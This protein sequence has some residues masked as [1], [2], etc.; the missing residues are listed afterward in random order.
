MIH[1]ISDMSDEIATYIGKK[2]FTIYKKNLMIDEE[3]YIRNTLTVRPFIP[4]SPIKLDSFPVYRES[5]KK[6]YIPR[7]FGIETYGAPDKINIPEGDDI[8]LKFKGDLRD[9]Q[10][11]IIQTYKNKIDESGGYG[12]GL[13]EIPCGRGK[14]LGKDTP[15]LMYN[16]SIKLVQDVRVG[17]ILMG[18]DS[19][20]RNVLSLARGRET[21]YE[22]KQSRGDAY[23]VNESHIL[24]LKDSDGNVVDISLSDYLKDKREDL[25]GYK[26]GIEYPK[27]E[28]D[29]TKYMN[30]YDFGFLISKN[31]L[32]EYKCIPDIY[33]LNCKEVQLDLITGLID[34]N[35]SNDCRHYYIM[36]KND[37]FID[38]LMF[39]CRCLKMECYM[40]KKETYFEIIL[41]TNNTKLNLRN[42]EKTIYSDVDDGLIDITISTISITKKDV[43][44]YYGFEI[45]GNRRFMLGDFTVTHNTVMALK[46]IELLKKKTL[47]IVHKGFLLNQWEERIEQFLPGARIGKIQGQIIDIENKDIV[48]AM[49]QSLSMKEYPENMFDSFGLTIVDEVHHISSEV[50][51][52]SLLKIITKYTLGLSATM[53]RKDGLSKVFKMFLGE[54]LYKEKRDTTDMVLIKALEYKVNDEKFNEIKY[55]FRGNPAYSSMISKLCEYAQRS[56]FILEVIKQELAEK[57]GQQIMILAHN[58]NILIYLF[59]AIEE[60]NIASVGYYLGGMKTDDLKASENKKII[61]ATYAMAAEA[62]DIKTLTTLILATPRTDV[63]QAVGRILRVKHERPLVVDIVDAHDLFKRQWKKREKYYKSNK[64]KIIYSDNT[65]YSSNEWDTIYDPKDKTKNTKKIKEKN[66]EL[67]GKCFINIVE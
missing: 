8:S 55:D 18:D 5:E 48:I 3:Q 4:N 37:K 19:K 25:F 21:M 2:G 58:K 43:D 29:E 54:I 32:S 56:E 50:F 67:K 45:D 35:Y 36:L 6:M 17:D 34:G 10:N 28:I 33:K 9:Y 61:I 66:E 49:L 41:N 64:Y 63:V 14:C 60:R 7:F 42:K 24:S 13:L 51:S 62:L 16:G 22:I 27:K 44:D 20:P 38:D 53:Q 57:D 47:V 65:R 40:E 1:H 15:I 52:R 23:T 39:I 46:I 26:A 31:N 12:G 11:N 30:P 59:K